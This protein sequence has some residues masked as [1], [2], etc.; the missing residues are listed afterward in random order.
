MPIQV[1][2]RDSRELRA[3]VLAIA[4]VGRD[5]K[6]QL[7]AQTKRV[8]APE[9]EKGIAERVHGRQDTAVL[10]RSARVQV[11]DT[12]VVLRSG[13]VGKF[14]DLTKAVEFGGDRERKKTYQSH[15]GA[16][17]FDV[18][19]HT[20]RQ[21]PPKYRKGRVVYPAATDLIPRLVAL[22]VQTTIRTFHEAIEKR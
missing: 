15:R 12:N 7:R 19:R 14:K 22:W 3:A 2:V 8:V 17:R 4:S 18:T 6:A 9:W 11:R 21:L 5:L 10:L 13:A 20:S 16:A 1:S